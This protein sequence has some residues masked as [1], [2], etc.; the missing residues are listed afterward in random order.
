MR[1]SFAFA[2]GS[3]LF[4]LALPCFADGKNA[5]EEP[6]DI[7]KYQ[8][9]RRLSYDLR[10]KPPSIDEYDALDS[11]DDVPLATIQEYLQ[12]DDFRLAM[13]RYHAD[14]FW[15]NLVA[16]SL[17]NQNSNISTASGGDIYY[18]QAAGRQTAFRG[19]AV[20]C[21]DRQNN[22]FPGGLKV[23]GGVTYE[24]WRYVTPYW[25]PTIQIKVCNFDAQE[26]ETAD[27]K[28]GPGCASTGKTDETCGCNTIAG[29]GATTCGCGP[30]L[31]YCYNGKTTEGEVQ[32]SLTEQLYRAIDKVTIGGAPYTDLMLS[33][34]ADQNGQI[35][36]WLQNLAPNTSYSK[37]Y[38]LADP[39]Q[40]IASLKYTDV[41][42]WQDVDRGAMHAG[43]LT[44]PGYL[45]RFQ[46]NRGR[47]NRWRIVFTNQY[48]I[49][50]SNLDDTKCDPNANDLTQKCNCRYCH[51]HLEP[52]AAHWGK[53]A[54][55]GTTLMSDDNVFPINDADCIDKPQNGFCA[56][57]YV[58]DSSQEN[59]GSLFPYQYQKEHP[60]YVDSINAG[61]KQLAQQIIDDGTFASA[62]VTELFTFFVKRA[63][64]TDGSIFDEQKT[65]SD[66]ASGFKKNGYSFVW[67]TQ[68]IVTLRQYGR[69]R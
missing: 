46:T 11:L 43:L 3:M 69:T 29:N 48:F 66:L 32:A 6:Q 56:R 60:D 27:V 16:A 54:E 5:C 59:P 15:P 30:N 33:T 23:V 45:L 1:T 13:R 22:A 55:A 67:L 63:P 41:D 35:A 65:I 31:Q 9:L 57:F 2:L 19:A 51:E 10:N 52:L 42:T 12:G 28:G 38:D 68:Q 58:T 4:A 40:E 24:G 8:L 25:D 26:T 7:D 14:L 44:M 39:G 17:F 18:I 21:D 49:P 37:T 34:H 61:P 62:T 47:A 36:F 53:F 50:P 64:I 20:G